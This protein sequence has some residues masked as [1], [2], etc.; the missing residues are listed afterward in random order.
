MLRNRNKYI[1]NNENVFTTIDE[2]D[3]KPYRNDA[4]YTNDN[5]NMNDISYYDYNT[6]VFSASEMYILSILGYIDNLILNKKI[7]L[8]N[9]NN[10]ISSSFG[11]IVS[12]YFALGYTPKEILG[13]FFELLKLNSDTIFN[14]NNTFGIFDIS[15]LV[16]KLLEPIFIKF[17]YFPTL[18]DIYNLTKKTCI[19]ITFQLNKSKV[20]LY[21]Y[22]SHPKV[23]INELIKNCCIIPF[24]FKKN[25]ENELC[26]DYSF[27]DNR[28]CD[29]I[30]DVLSDNFDSLKI[31][32]FNIN[33]MNSN[34]TSYNK[35]TNLIQYLKQMTDIS[36]VKLDTNLSENNIY[37]IRLNVN[38]YDK[39]LLLDIEQRYKELIKL[40]CSGY[41]NYNNMKN[42][43][44]TDEINN[45]ND[46]NKIK[47]DIC[48]INENCE[49][50]VI[51]GG[52]TNV[53]NLLGCIKYCLVNDV[54]NI[55][56]I[57]TFIGTSA[58]SYVCLL[59]AMG[60]DID[61]ITEIYINSEINKKINIDIY[62][63]NIIER[64]SEK[65]IYSNK[66]II[67]IY[68]KLFIEKNDGIIPTLL[69]IKNKYD[70][71][72]VVTVYNLTKNK[73]EYLNYL[74]S[75]DLL[76][77]HACAMSSC[78]P[79]AFNPIEYN[80]CF[81]ID[82]GIMSNYPIECTNNYP[83]KKFIGF[84]LNFFSNYNNMNLFE[85]FI[86]FMFETTRNNQVKLIKKSKNC[87]TYRFNIVYDDDNRK[88]KNFLS[89]NQQTVLNF[90]NN[91]YEY[92]KTL[93]KK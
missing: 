76:V 70:K 32:H 6:L 91:G 92:M 88:G 18:E 21:S 41:D 59:L 31:L 85:Y 74:N 14:I 34:D 10:F 13:Y 82:G 30:K 73:I 60:Y 67:E 40:Y 19:F 81:Y 45:N 42:N 2:T 62:N 20:V 35:D 23:K 58:G 47:D 15:T 66:I 48:C 89:I 4:K 27:I 46:N 75:P 50:I 33:I 57:N 71:E 28:E 55:Q 39:T 1:E 53:F 63:I 86:Y 49:G 7:N 69:D 44:Y 38:S 24:I 36:Q 3:K 93:I 12:I 72:V 17:G 37:K 79:I 26:I 11:T 51:S 61:Q 90:I 29:Y 68:E 22:K 25:I 54:I 16:D 77:T 80:K 87:V 78:I 56:N 5:E 84:T 43:N 64:I 8:K 83:K 52:G 9:I 65:S